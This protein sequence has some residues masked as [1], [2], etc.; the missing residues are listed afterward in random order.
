M[1]RHHSKFME[2]AITLARK[3]KV[4]SGAGPFGA[5]I[6]KDD[7]I[8]AKAYNKVG[9]QQDPTQHAELAVIQ[10]ACKVLKS[11]DLSGCILYTSC[12]PC[13]M[14]LGACHWANFDVIYFGASADDAKKN[15][16]IYSQVF[17]NSDQEKRYQE[18][19]MNQLLRDLAIKVWQD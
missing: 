4:T 1:D 7:Q 9:K 12:E 14:C 16:F 19:N 6:V 10:K 13:M 3:G 5:V 2:L 17:Y 18:F 8:I 15:G 11:K